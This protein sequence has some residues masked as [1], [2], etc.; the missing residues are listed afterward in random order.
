[1]VDLTQH[2]PLGASGM[3][4]WMPCPGSVALSY[5]VE[6]EENEYSLPGIQAHAL[7]EHCQRTGK[8]AWELVRDDT[9]VTKEMADAVQVYVNAVRKRHPKLQSPL[10]CMDAYI[11]LEFYC[12]S[13]HEYCWGKAD[14]A[15]YEWEENRTLHAWDYKHGAGIIVEVR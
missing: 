12:P 3:Y 4:R 9:V 7:A 10:L 2:S 8:D 14:F 15:F 6:D 13:I 11:E 5:G 1:M